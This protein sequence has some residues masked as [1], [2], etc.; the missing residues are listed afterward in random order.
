MTE[1]M[2]FVGRKCVEVRCKGACTRVVA[3]DH[4]I[5][6]QYVE[7]VIAMREPNGLFSKHETAM[8]RACKTRIVSDGPQ[9][10]ELEAIYA[11]DMAQMISCA[12]RGGT[13]MP[14]AL[15]M[16]EHFIARQPLRA[17]N[18]KGRGEE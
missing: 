10:G 13:S 8:C 4:G 9:P 1:Y 2:T 11:Q 16:A 18:E 17:L 3:T 15:R 12:V 14:E 6:P 7:L 5:T